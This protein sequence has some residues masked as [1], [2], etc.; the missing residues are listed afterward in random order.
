MK[1][2]KVILIS[3]IILLA[4]LPVHAAK[5]IMPDSSG[6]VYLETEKLQNVYTGG[7][8]VDIN[9]DIERDLVVAGNIITINRDIEDDLIVAGGTILVR[10]KIGGSARIAGV[11]SLS[12]ARLT[13][14]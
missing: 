8:I 1:T 11:T 13:K 10:G 3:S 4:V 6:N 5:I 7:N 12:K 2:I 14:I 9:S